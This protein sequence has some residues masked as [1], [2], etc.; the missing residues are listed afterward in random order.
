[1]P[2]WRTGHSQEGQEWSGVPPEGRQWLVGPPRGLG[3]VRRPF[4]WAA[5]VWEGLERLGGLPEGQEVSGGPF[6]GL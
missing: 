3:G 2:F 1:M 4:R 6:G 5:R